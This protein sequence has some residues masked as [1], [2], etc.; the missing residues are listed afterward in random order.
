MVE[1]YVLSG[2][3]WWYTEEV[4]PAFE[5]GALKE[6]VESRTRG[7]RRLKETPESGGG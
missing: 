2:T 3:G 7:V 6:E 4:R 5:L 1:S